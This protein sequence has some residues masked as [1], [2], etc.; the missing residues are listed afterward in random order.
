[1]DEYHPMVFY[2]KTERIQCA[3][4]STESNPFIENV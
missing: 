1:M 3:S 2:V 4:N